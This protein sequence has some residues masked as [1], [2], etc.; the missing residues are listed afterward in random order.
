MERLKNILK[1]KTLWGVIGSIVILAIVAIAFF[2][3]DAGEGNVLRQHDMVQG[4]ANGHETEVY[5]QQT[6]HQAR[7]TGSLFSGMPTFQISPSYESDGMFRWI[8]DVMG[9]W[10]PNPSNLLFMMM[11]GFFILLMVM[12]VRW[13]L[14]LI[15]AIAYGLSS[16]FIIII[17]AGH[18]W[19]FVTLA[20]IP[21]TIAGIV[22]CYR[23][24]YLA[25]GAL[26]ALFAMMQIAANHV[27]MTYY[28]LAVVLGFAIVYLI[29]AVRTHA[30]RHWLIATGVLLLAG[31]AATVANLPSLYNTYEYSKLTIRGGHSELAPESDSNSTGKGLDRDYITQYSYGRSESV[32]LLIPNVKGGATTKPMKG[33]NT[34]MTLGN[35]DEARAMYESGEIGP[36]AMNALGQVYQYFGEPEGTNGP[37]YVGALIFALFALGCV[38]VRGPMKWVL[39]TLTVLSILLALGR[40]CM[41]LTDLMIDYMPMYNKFRTPESILV[42]A[43]FTMPLMAVLA[44]QQLLKEGAAEGWKRYGRALCWSFGAVLLL[45]VAGIFMPSVYGSALSAPE[46][47]AG[48]QQLPFY[49][50]IE[51]L[52]Y[53]MVSSDSLR[54]FCI[55]VLGAIAI[56]LFWRRSIPAA[57]AMGAIGV[58]VLADLYTAD[59]RYVSHESFTASLSQNP[60]SILPAP[61][62]EIILSDGTQ[63]ALADGSTNYRVFDIPRFSSAEPSYFH[64]MVGGYHAAKLTRYQDVLEYYIMNPERN[65]DNIVNMLNVRYIVED[66]AQM[67]MLNLRALGEAW[68]VDSVEYVD[69]PQAEIA[70]IED[71]DIATKAVADS[72]FRDILGTGTPTTPGD[73]IVATSYAPDRLTYNVTSERG[74]VAVLSE[75]YFPWGWKATIDGNPAEIGRVNYILRAVKMPEGTH[76]LVLTFD[77]DSLHTTTA[78]ARVAIIIIFAALVAAAVIPIIRRKRTTDGK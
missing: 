23:G 54:S 63:W 55:V 40:N 11:A 59:K 35:L 43:E 58:I 41:W 66:P 37:V 33:S 68:L 44:L 39:L 25:G 1:D 32:S 17:G 9:L 34:P 75:V 45:C 48:Y 6:G 27:Q 22:L 51:S 52:R 74:G 62:D 73:T 12:R 7:W 61:A 2:Y 8:N 64:K 14:A 16:Y 53:S 71:L 3:P 5:A 78:A 50:A 21:P 36:E 29:D 28:F 69:T 49:N 13:Y 24:R 56:V 70:A 19:K 26:A 76:E 67:P 31:G 46:M 57:A 4:T 72:K 60:Q 38:I 30:L 47:E 77:P 20:Y 10:L 65:P 42:I 18:I 15:G